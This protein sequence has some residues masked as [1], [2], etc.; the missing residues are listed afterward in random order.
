M[1]AKIPNT[2]STWASFYAELHCSAEKLRAMM[3]NT[4]SAAPT[5][6]SENATQGAET[7]QLYV[8]AN[9]PTNHS[10]KRH[11]GQASEVSK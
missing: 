5:D 7:D 11:A 8:R 9:Q 6:Q 10:R 1:S 3:K 4:P 2:S